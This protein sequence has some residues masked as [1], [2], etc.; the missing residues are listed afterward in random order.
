MIWIAR[1]GDRAEG[2]K[3]AAVHG[4][5]VEQDADADGEKRAAEEEEGDPGEGLQARDG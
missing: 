2:V 4:G 5:A 1:R 3:A